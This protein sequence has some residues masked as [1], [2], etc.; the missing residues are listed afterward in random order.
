MAAIRSSFR[1]HCLSPSRAR[2]PID[3]AVGPTRYARV[4]PDRD[5]SSLEGGAFELTASSANRSLIRFSSS[6]AMSTPRPP[7]PAG[8]RSRPTPSS[9]A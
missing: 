8:S 5:P 6:V 2:L 1:T 3:A 7:E 4:L 9:G